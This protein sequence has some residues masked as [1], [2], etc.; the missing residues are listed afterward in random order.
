MVIKDRERTEKPKQPLGQKKQPARDA[1][2][3]RSTETKRKSSP[4][5]DAARKSPKSQ[6]AILR[7][8]QDTG[9]ELR[10][11]AWPT[12][13]QAVRLTLIVLGSIVVT[14]TFFGVLDKFFQ[15]LA[16]FLV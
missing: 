16:S 15:W 5:R 1:K 3:E 2:Q 6:N 11:V 12:R 10:K 8:F 14:A 9:D 13:E 7:Y 4:R